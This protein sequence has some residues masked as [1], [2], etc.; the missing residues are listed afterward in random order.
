MLAAVG[1]EIDE[2]TE[3][4]SN[5]PTAGG[6]GESQRDAPEAAVAEAAAELEA[7]RVSSSTGRTAR[8]RVS[9]GGGSS[10]DR[11]GGGSG[12]GGVGGSAKGQENATAKSGELSFGLDDECAI[13]YDEIKSPR[14]LPCGHWFC[15][16]CIDKLCEHN[17]LAVC[18]KVC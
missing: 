13:C 11:S 14:K 7:E 8:D 2:L 18:P 12:G 6:A 5:H 16:R 15:G 1:Q 17:V 3:A 9:G 10:G 4:V